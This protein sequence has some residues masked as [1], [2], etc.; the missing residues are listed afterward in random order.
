MRKLLGVLGALGATLCLATLAGAE[1]LAWKGVSVIRLG[2]AGTP[3]ILT[4]S[5][6]ATVNSSAGGGHLNTL[7]LA[8]GI[9]G[10]VVTPVTDPEVTAGGIVELDNTFLGGSG[11]LKPISGALQN[12]A[13]A[14]TM[15]VLPVPGLGRVCLLFA[16]CNSG[17]L[18][19]PLTTN[20]GASGAGIGGIVTAGGVG[21]IRISLVAAPWTIKTAT[22]SDRTDNGALSYPTA[23]GFAHGPASMTSSTALTSGVVQLVNPTQVITLGIPG[24][25]DRISLYGKLTIHFVPE[26][27]VLLLLVSGVAGLVVLGRAKM[28][29]K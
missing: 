10:R 13:Q 23:R 6:A 5:G 20:D 12:T 16:G 25:Q 11:T 21:G 2:P 18:E 27:G 1:T 29:G 26:P 14:L 22:L 28:R 24:Q 9:S 7:R 17:S 15:N 4:G 8:G 19:F 3:T